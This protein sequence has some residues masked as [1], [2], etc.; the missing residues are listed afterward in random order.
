MS[1]A[2]R[3][4]LIMKPFARWQNIEECKQEQINIGH[5]EKA[6][7]NICEI[8]QE[9]AEKGTL[10]KAA[11]T[12][13]IL[14]SAD[15]ELVVG[16]PASWELVDYENDLVTTEA[17]VNFLTKFFNLPEEYR[18]ISIDHSNFQIAKAVLQYPEDNPK[19]FSHVHEKGMWLIAKVRNDNLAHTQYYRK[20]IQD[21]TYKMFSISGK[22]IRCDGPCEKNMRIGKKIR[23]IFDIDP[24][25]VGIV[26]EGMNRKAGP[27]Q[28]LKQKPLHPTDRDRLINHYG[29]E[30]ALKLIEL[31]GLEEASRLLPPRQQ[32]HQK[33]EKMKK[34]DIQKKVVQRGE[35]WCVVHCHEDGSVG[36]TIKCFDTKQEADAM[37]RAIQANKALTKD[38]RPPKPWWDNCIGRAESFASDPEAFCND[39]WHEG[40]PDKRE[41]FGKKKE[42][43]FKQEAEKIFRKHF[44]DYKR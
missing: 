7:L 23:K 10:F 11:P 28:V 39:L 44:P 32:Q 3:A 14:K 18:N 12:L 30:K 1:L 36:E 9:R 8:I 17:M 27:L 6:A 15:G 22:P 24:V 21:G 31:I 35:K 42:L 16:G 13:Q 5:T 37:H 33:E 38:E 25:E 4:P 19:W 40:P 26:K 41:A 29:E 43:T 20:L 34:Q 2:V